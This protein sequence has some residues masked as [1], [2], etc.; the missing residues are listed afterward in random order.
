MSNPF[1][2]EIRMMAS[3]YAPVH[4]AFCDGQLMAI[5]SNQALF[6]LLGTIY[7]GD[8]RSSFALPDMRGRLPVSY[9]QGPGLT[10]RPLGSRFG[11]EAVTLNNTEV[12]PHNHSFTVATGDA[13][14]LTAGG[15]LP[16]TM[17]DA[18]D[19][20]AVFY[21]TPALANA[22]QPMNPAAMS[23]EGGNDSHTN[24]MPALCVNFIMCI[25]G[26]YP[27]RN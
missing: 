10:Q 4:W 3:T 11:S 13:T 12:P 26:V 16:A 18:T 9:G 21:E 14:S 7:G 17:D 20:G 25:Q 19:P 2:G 5:G 24:L 6:S 8:G 22:K 15:Q 27:S 1:M 23:T